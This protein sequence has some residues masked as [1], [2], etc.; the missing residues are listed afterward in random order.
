MAPSRDKKLTEKGEGYALQSAI[1]KVKSNII[2]VRKTAGSAQEE[3]N[4]VDAVS[5]KTKSRLKREIETVSLDDLS[6]RINS[7]KDKMET[8]TFDKLKDDMNRAKVV[9]NNALDA[10]DAVQLCN[11]SEEVNGDDSAD[12]ENGENEDPGD[13]RSAHSDTWQSSEGAAAVKAIIQGLEATKMPVMEPE[14]FGGETM[15]F[16]MWEA[17]MDMLVEGKNLKPQQK[18]MLLGRYL[19][20]E[21]LQAVEGLL[22][23]PAN[24]QSYDEARNLLKERFG[25]THLAC[26][27]FREKLEGWPKTSSSEEIL[28]YADFLRQL[29]IAKRSQTGLNVL[30]DPHE[31]MKVADK[32][33]PWLASRWD[34]VAAGNN[35]SAKYPVFEKIAKFVA[36]E[37]RILNSPYA[38]KVKNSEQPS[39]TV[40]RK[41]TVRAVKTEID[42]KPAC[43]FLRHSKSLDQRV[44]KVG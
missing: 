43:L 16:L 42:E 10:I 27:A 38:R 37:A 34:R 18:M 28:R 19:R 23:V 26:E 14:V 17:Q 4:A 33:P 21:A 1:N 32:L 44:H 9:R 41:V 35:A 12:E 15:R 2:L 13:E 25:H 8:G 40:D 31:V 30:D 29:A 11:E 36:E 5:E 24:S 3:I 7:L 22:L 6:E 39:R 20:D